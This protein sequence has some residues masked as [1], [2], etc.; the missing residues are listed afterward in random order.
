MRAFMLR[1]V[2][3][4]TFATCNALGLLDD[5]STMCDVQWDWLKRRYFGGPHFTAVA[6]QVTSVV[7][8]PTRHTHCKDYTLCS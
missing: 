2:D 4:N 3:G 7:H 6:P 5:K 1:Y 8:G